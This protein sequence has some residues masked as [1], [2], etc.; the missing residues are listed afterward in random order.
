VRYLLEHQLL[1]HLRDE[2]MGEAGRRNEAL[3]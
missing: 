3:R 2:V 1:E